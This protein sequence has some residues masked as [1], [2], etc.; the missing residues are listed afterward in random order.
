MLRRQVLLCLTLGVALSAYGDTDEGRQPAPM[1]QRIDAAISAAHFGNAAPI[2]S[3]AEFLRRAYLDLVGR[4]PT[5]EEAK[6]FLADA[7]SDKRS[8]AIDKLINADE[9]ND[10]FAAVLDIMLLERRVEKRIP[11]A[12]WRAY[13]RRALVEKQPFDEIARTILAADGTGDLRGAAKFLLEHEVEPNAL[14]RDV[15]RIFLGRDLQCAQCHDHPIIDDYLQ[16]EYYGIY[17]FVNRSYLFEDEADKKKAYVGEKAEGDTEYKSV[18]LPDDGTSQTIPRLLGELTL[19]VEPRYDGEDAYVVAPSKKTAGVPKF[20]R[21]SQLARLVTHPSND[22]FT[23]NIAN[24]LWA[25]MMG[26]GIVEPVDFHYDDNPPSHPAL[27]QSLADEFVAM[28]FDIREF[29]RQ[30]ALSD[31]YQR[32]V[33]FPAEA[34]VSIADVETEIQNSNDVI[35]KLEAIRDA[36]N[37]RGPFD[38]RLQTARGDVAQIDQAISDAAKRL[39]EFDKQQQELAKSHQEL[40]KQLAAKQSQLATLSNAVAAAKKA[41]AAIPDDKTLANAHAEYKNRAEKTK[42]E[43]EA[44]QKT[45]TENQQKSDAA[46]Q[47]LATE[48]RR[49]ASLKSDRVGL[50]DMVA[51]ARGAL[52]VFRDRQQKHS[53]LLNEKRQRLAALAFHRVYLAKWNAQKELAARHAELAAAPISDAPL[54]QLAASVADAEVQIAAKQES[55]AALSEV[56]T[57]TD[58]DLTKKSAAF[59]AL[60]EAINRL[61]SAAESLTDPQLNDTVEL[62]TVKQTTLSEELETAKEEANQR[63]AELDAAHTELKKLNT[64][65]NEL[66]AQRENL[67]ARIAQQQQD[68]STAKASRDSAVVEANLAGTQLRK[69]WERRFAV[70]SL[71]P[72]TPEQLTG[73]TITA[74][75]L[76]ARFQLEAEKEWENKNKDKK[77]EEIDESKKQSEIVNLVRKRIAQVERTYVSLFAA[78]AG[79][80]QDVFSATADQAL[81]LANDGRVQNWL[82][83]SEG[84]LIRRL[85]S[86]EDA[87]E[88]AD[89][90]NLAILSRPATETEK[91]QVAEYLAKRTDDRNK[92]IQELAWG[93]LS[94]LA[95]RFNH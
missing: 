18:F 92:A 62:L 55:I 15:G 63:N 61:K 17:A 6:S 40:E 48:N 90:L 95:F 26:R 87:T 53:T 4:S 32:S 94:S 44:H 72:L 85:Q 35:A 20:S 11:Q 27:L 34:A 47:Q 64:D 59:D 8:G 93:L 60:Q 12:E 66:V 51:E 25:H 24:R 80:P 46:G 65:K 19:D 58:G 33:D 57:S 81:F 43:V 30:I 29:L 84:T 86:V 67:L 36:D 52:G 39:G 7:H 10:V 13:L 79:A 89:E 9:F 83:P 3:D 82:S 16:A 5:A 23:R 75:G 78:P 37:E 45:I 76:N 50:V 14:T 49:L 56:A 77:P 70:R 69:S 71:N 41:A 73:S 54:T 22:H 42:Q 68:I 91:Q 88:L 31:T 74:L 1:H 28:K 21:R 2:A 38:A